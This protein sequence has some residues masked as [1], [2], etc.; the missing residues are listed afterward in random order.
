MASVPSEY[1]DLF[2]VFLPSNDFS[3]SP[4]YSHLDHHIPLIE[5]AKPI[6][7]SIYNL[8]EMKLQVLKNYVEKYL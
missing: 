7:G 4:H 6:Y 8:S 5:G 2:E 1:Y 3:L